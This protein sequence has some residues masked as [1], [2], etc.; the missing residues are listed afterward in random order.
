MITEDLGLSVCRY[1]I[2]TGKLI[3]LYK[4]ISTFE[5]AHLLALLEMNNNSVGE[6]V[7]ILP[8][9]NMRVDDEII[10]RQKQLAEKYKIE[11]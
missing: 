3:D 11:E 8:G 6:I 1:N 4:Y 10:K 5:E 9:W 2:Y 7:V